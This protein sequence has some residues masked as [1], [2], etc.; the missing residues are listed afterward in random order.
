MVYCVGCFRTFSHNKAYSIHVG[1]SRNPACNGELED[2]QEQCVKARQLEP[3][4]VMEVE[5]EGFEGNEHGE[6]NSHAGQQSCTARALHLPHSTD[7][8]YSKGPVPFVGDFYAPEPAYQPADLPGWGDQ[9]DWI[10]EDENEESADVPQAF[11]D[12][13]HV[14]TIPSDDDSDEEDIAGCIRIERY[15]GATLA[16]DPEHQPPLSPTSGVCTGFAAMPASESPSHSESETTTSL[17]CNAE[18]GSSSA[19]AS[20]SSESRRVRMQSALRRAVY[21]ERFPTHTCAGQ[22]IAQSASDQA[23]VGYAQYAANFA[24]AADNPYAPFRAKMEWDIV[25]WA[26][27]RGKGSTASTELL[28]IDGVSRQH[29]CI[30]SCLCVP[31]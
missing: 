3:E 20:D 19:S 23:A 8:D 10:D 16:S 7:P 15:H 9:D 5:D 31:L 21:V 11:D 26:K 25:R 30:Q 18:F 22:P 1:R 2:M 17:P 27:L 24:N 4:V 13:A 28:S 29:I 6:I 14:A 12:P